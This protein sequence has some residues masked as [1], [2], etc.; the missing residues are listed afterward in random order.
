LAT[1]SASFYGIPIGFFIGGLA[2]TVAYGT[3]ASD[4]SFYA[5]GITYSGYILSIFYSKVE[6]SPNGF[7]FYN[8]ILFG[9]TNLVV[10]SFDSN[11]L[12]I[13]KN[14]YFIAGVG[15]VSFLV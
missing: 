10:S 14:D 3:T 15:F 12:F 11:I 7:F 1:L 4:F 2:Y 9:A 13:C 6:K 8:P 5:L